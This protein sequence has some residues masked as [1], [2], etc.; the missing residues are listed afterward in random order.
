MPNRRPN[1]VV[2]F[3]VVVATV[4]GSLAFGG[5]AS[6]VRVDPPGHIDANHCVN[7]FGVDLNELF[8]IS[9]QIRSFSC[10]EVTAGEHW[11]ANVNWIT[12]FATGT[13][14]PAGYVASRAAPLDDFM[15]KLV[16]VEVVI[17]VGT[18]QKRTYV[19]NPAE[20]VRTDINAAQ[21]F[22]GLWGPNPM[23]AILPRLDPLSV[24][25][26]TAQVLVL[27]TAQHCDGLTTN[28]A[29]SC[30]QA[31]DTPISPVLPL[32]VRTPTP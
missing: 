25:Q 27:L 28:V 32:T 22:P 18:S 13:V 20:V 16:A 21:E 4:M 24:G 10:R 11:V 7:L 14:Y 12:G 9:D 15:A 2:T 6:A 1:L 3:L 19:F 26:H 17:D 30:L 8:G 29:S 31:G 5:A 23:A